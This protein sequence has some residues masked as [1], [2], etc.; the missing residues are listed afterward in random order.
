MYW[1]Q[2]WLP[3]RTPLHINL[4]NSSQKALRY[5]ARRQINSVDDSIAACKLQKFRSQSYSQI[6][7]QQL[8][9]QVW[10]K[11]TQKIHQGSHHTCSSFCS[12]VWHSQRHSHGPICSQDS[13]EVVY[14][15]LQGNQADNGGV[16][17]SIAAFTTCWA[18]LKLYSYLEDLQQQILYFDTYSVIFSWK[19]GQSDIPLGDFLGKMTN[20]KTEISSSISPQQD[21]RT[22]GTRQKTVKFA[23]KCVGLLSMFAVSNSSTTTSCVKTSWM[24][25]RILLTNTETS[26]SSIPDS[27]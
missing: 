11:S 21:Q 14:T 8:L 13:L 26:T 2:Q 16:N 18:C 12:S 3:Y 15:N 25:W 22:M 9:G 1:K 23:A 24:N 17:I 7:A 20:W 27:S 5:A 6:D 19:P 10:W 4:L